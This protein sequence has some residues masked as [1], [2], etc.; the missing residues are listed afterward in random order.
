[1]FVDAARHVARA[2]A[3]ERMC[4][5]D[6]AIER[7]RTAFEKAIR[8]PPEGSAETTEIKDAN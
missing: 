7:I 4:T 6:E 1:V 2:F 5:E 3:H 8:E